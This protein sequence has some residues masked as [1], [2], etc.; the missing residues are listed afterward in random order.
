MRASA[1]PEHSVSTACACAVSCELCPCALT[2]PA[3]WA[4]C[5][6]SCWQRPGQDLASRGRASIA[7]HC[8]EN[9]IWLLCCTPHM[10][11]LGLAGARWLAATP[12]HSPAAKHATTLT[13]QIK[14]KCR[15]APH[16]T[17][18]AG[19]TGVRLG[20]HDA[21]TSKPSRAT[22]SNATFA[23][24]CCCSRACFLLSVNIYIPFS[25]RAP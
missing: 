25:C 8:P 11:R 1:L 2:E 5:Q 15:K 16:M 20:L 18:N 21:A 6:A 14:F 17:W 10:H 4:C 3:A 22:T 7:D 23:L 12:A 13:S 24:Y 9:L 19:L